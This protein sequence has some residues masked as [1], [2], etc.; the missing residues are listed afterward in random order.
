MLRIV[1]MMGMVQARSWGVCTMNEFRAFLGLKQFATFEEWN[2]DPEIAQ[3]AR[4]LYGHIDNLELYPGLQAEVSSRG[5][6]GKRRLMC[7]WGGCVGD[8]ADGAGLGLVLWLHDDA[9]HPE[10]RDCARA[11]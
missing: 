9:C 1:E 10:R 4:Q 7:D 11:R 3:A 2:P 5:V 6:R 8:C